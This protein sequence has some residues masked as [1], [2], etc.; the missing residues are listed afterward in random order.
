MADQRNALEIQN[1]GSAVHGITKFSD[2]DQVEFERTML[3]SDI[4]MK[5]G[6]GALVH[7]VSTLVEAAAG[8]SVD[9]SGKLTTPVKDQGYCGIYSLLLLLLLLLLL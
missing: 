9:W 8:S 1:G 7:D 6:V 2:L 5:K 4:S 3:K